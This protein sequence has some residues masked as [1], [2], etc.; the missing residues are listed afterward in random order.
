ML[1][2]W[3]VHSAILVQILPNLAPMQRNTAVGFVLS[4]L[5]LL[6]IVKDRLRLTLI[7]GVVTAAFAALT[8]LE[9]L[10]RANFGIDE[11]LGVSYITTHTSQAGRMSPTTAFCFLV[12]AT[13]FL[14]AQTASRQRRSAVLGV[15]GL[16]AAAVGITCCIGVLL[17]TSDAFAWGD[18]TRVALHT[19]V[20]FAILG[21]GTAAVALD[22]T[23]PEFREPLWVPIGASLVIA[24]IRVGSWQAWAAKNQA[25][26]ELLSNLMLLSAIS[27]AILFGVV[28]HLALKA[29]LH[30]E[31]LRA[32]N[33]KLE[34]EMEDRRRAEQAANAA[35]RAKSEFLADVEPRASHADE[36]DSRH[37][38]AG[39]GYH[40]RC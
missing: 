12:L 8:L 24:M 37:G 27:S 32:A 40:A 5:A 35:N 20:G 25:K 2:G 39:A 19:A 34:R 21:I 14:M 28:V 6:G 23:Q 15:A 3:A 29:H 13:G 4:G 26:A 17:G 30:R 9:Y 38:R 22:I 10:F 18:L 33:R 1:L 11:L 31:E 36:W 16:L 7:G